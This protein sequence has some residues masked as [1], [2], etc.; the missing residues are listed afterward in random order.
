MWNRTRPHR[1]R[2]SVRVHSAPWWWHLEDEFARGGGGQVDDPP[3]G[4]RVEHALVPTQ[5]PRVVDLDDLLLQHTTLS[6]RSSQGGIQRGCVL[7]HTVLHAHRTSPHPPPGCIPLHTHHVHARTFVESHS[8]TP[9]PG[10][11]HWSAARTA[12]TRTHTRSPGPR[13]HTCTHTH[14]I[15]LQSCT[16]T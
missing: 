12:L 11:T 2:Q 16:H 13:F 9:F 15:L 1:R 10:Q 8:L 14:W 6:W 3:G 7:P 5:R 4:A